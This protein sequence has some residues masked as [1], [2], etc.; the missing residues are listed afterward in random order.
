[1][2]EYKFYKDYKDNAMLRT[3]FN[4]LATLIFGL[5]FEEWYENGFWNNR[6]IP[7]SFVDDNKVIA[8][9][10]VNLVDFVIDGLKKSAIQIGTVMTHPNYRNRGLSADLIN[11]VLMDFEPNY[12]YIYLFANQ[13]VLQFYPKFGFSQVSECQYSMPYIHTGSK[14]NSYRK[15]DCNN[16]EDL[17]FIYDFAKERTPVSNLFGTE[18]TDDLLMFYC[19]YVLCDYVYYLEEENVIIMFERDGA[20]IEIFDILSKTEVDLNRILSTITTHE[21]NEIIFH[22]TPDY[23]GYNMKKEKYDGDD[24]LFVKANRSNVFPSQIKHPLTS[25]A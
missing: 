14:Q 16:P 10:S 1:M 17:R 19:L 6:Y 20:R 13:S 18:N 23:D 4:E 24:V 22:Y 8:N 12:E 21:K 11:K 7:Y 5:N 2:K 3:S 15:L 25:K 9:V